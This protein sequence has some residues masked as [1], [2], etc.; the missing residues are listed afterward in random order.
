MEERVPPG[1]MKRVAQELPAGSEVPEERWYL[2]FGS[3]IVVGKG[4][5]LGTYLGREMSKVEGYELRC[6]WN[7]KNNPKC[8]RNKAVRKV[9][10]DSEIVAAV[11]GD[12]DL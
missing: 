9:T 7:N 6:W 12:D 10:P 8:W 2:D 1:G 4:A 11:F 3:F 5:Y